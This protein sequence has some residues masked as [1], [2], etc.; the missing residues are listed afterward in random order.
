MRM[1][2]HDHIGPGINHLLHHGTLLCRGRGRIFLAHMEEA[3]RCIGF[4]VGLGNIRGSI[5][6]TVVLY[7]LP[8]V[9][10]GFANYRMLIYAVVL[11]LVMLTTNNPILQ[12][13]FARIRESFGK[14]KDKEV[15]DA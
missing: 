7:I 4:R 10:R 3:H 8:E 5:I 6:A 14:R 13:Y 15:Q 12:G 1:R 2:T 9:L 11:I